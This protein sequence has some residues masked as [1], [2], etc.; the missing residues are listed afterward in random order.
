MKK[1]LF[2]AVGVPVLILTVMAGCGQNSD[3]TGPGSNLDMTNPPPAMS[4]NLPPTTN[5][6]LINTNLTSNATGT[7][8][9]NP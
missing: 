6:D 8:T 5:T 9:N 3:K 7:A 2:L 1:K 4:T